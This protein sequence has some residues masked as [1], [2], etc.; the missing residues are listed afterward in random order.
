MTVHFALLHVVKTTIALMEKRLMRRGGLD[1]VKKILLLSANA[2]NMKEENTFLPTDYKVPTSS[3]YLKLSEGEHTFR[4][5][6]SAIVGYEYF[7][8]ENKPVRSR[9]AFEE[10]P[11]DLKEGGRINPFWAFVIY[12]YDEKRIQILEIT[13]KTIMLP[14]KALVDNKK[15]GNPKLYDIT[16]TRKGTGMQDTEYAVM[17]NPHTEI[18]PDIASAFMAKK[19]NLDALFTGQDP[20]SNDL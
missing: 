20:F 9:E 12:N 17:P 16:I 1:E 5:L 8:T 7:N 19:V 14:M 18:A 6:S 4:V 10:V 11:Q 2:N 3:N 13:Q 15:W